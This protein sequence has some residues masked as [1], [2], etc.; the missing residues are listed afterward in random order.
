VTAPAVRL[1]AAFLSGLFL[2]GAV[3][4]SLADAALFHEAGHDPYAGVTHLESRGGSHHADRCALAVPHAPSQS[5]PQIDRA[6]IA[7]GEP[8]AGRALCPTDAAPLTGP[9]SP[10]RSRAPPHTV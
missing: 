8:V 6:V 3:G 10:H 4:V 5:A 1:R 2:L 9:T 7:L